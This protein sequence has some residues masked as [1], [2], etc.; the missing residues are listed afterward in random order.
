MKITKLITGIL[1]LLCATQTIAQISIGLKSGYTRAWQ[2]YGDVVVP[3][4]AV[5]HIHGF[6]VT[7][8]TYL[9]INKYIEVGVEPGFI[10]RGAA[11]VPGWNQLIN[12]NPVFPGDS[13]FIL[14]YIELPIMAK[15]N[16]PLF[17]NK[18]E[19]F[20]K[21]GYGVSMLAKGVRENETT[22]DR[23]NIDLGFMSI[24]NRWDHGIYSTLG[25][26]YN[27]KSSQIYIASDFYTGL[28]NVERFNYSRNRSLGF[29]LGYTYTFKK[30]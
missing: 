4:G 26:A 21:A 10:R 3:E 7:A 30:P 20:G 13:K 27:F 9:Q 2:N 24:L 6:H 29:N 28:T 17:K 12:P 19:I 5:V 16:L 1:F 23:T 14:D 22:G 18:F 15:F 25:F 11:C 8:S